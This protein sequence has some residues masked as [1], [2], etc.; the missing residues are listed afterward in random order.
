MK[1]YIVQLAGVVAEGL[2]ALGCV[3]QLG[4]EAPPAVSILWPRQGDAFSISMLVRIK[5]DAISP[6][7]SIAQVTV[8]C[9]YE[10]GRRGHESPVRPARP[11][12]SGG[13]KVEKSRRFEIPFSSGGFSSRSF[14]LKL[15]FLL[16]IP[17]SGRSSF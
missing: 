16:P 15:F 3:G 4:A 7:G 9:R 17:C 8:L 10:C 1:G 11:A 12:V 13:M 14:T 5:A 2:L 6:G